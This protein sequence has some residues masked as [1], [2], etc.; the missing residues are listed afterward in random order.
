M[1]L[2]LSKRPGEADLERLREHY[3][4]TLAADVLREESPGG[5]RWRHGPD[6]G[7]GHRAAPLRFKKNSFFVLV[8]VDSPEAA[9]AR[10]QGLPGGRARQVLE[11]HRL[12]CNAGLCDGSAPS[13]RA[14]P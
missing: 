13:A 8:D 4:K 11:N 14:G 12:L 9:R 7:D 1:S 2:S 3:A 5:R 6:R 10:C